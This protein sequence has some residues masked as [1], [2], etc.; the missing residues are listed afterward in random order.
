[1]EAGALEALTA[2]LVGLARGQPAPPRAALAQEPG[3][4]Q[5]KRSTS[6]V[7]VIPVTGIITYKRSVFSEFF[8]GTALVNVIAEINTAVDTPGVGAI[9]MPFDSPGGTASGLIET[10]AVIRAARRVKPVVAVVD[11]LAASAAFWLAT[12]ATEIVITPSGHTGSLG[13]FA[14]HLSF[15]EALKKA[16]VK[17]TFISST[18]EKV[19]Q[20]EALPLS[21]EAKAAA[22]REVDL[23]Y[24]AFLS[25][26]ALGRGKEV[27]QVR[28]NFGRGRLV[29]AKD[30]V[31]AGLVDR[32]GTLD[33]ALSATL[34]LL[35]RGS[36][37]A[38]APAGGTALH[39]SLPPSRPLS[40]Y[41]HFLAMQRNLRELKSTP[42][43]RRMLV[44]VAKALSTF[45]PPRPSSKPSSNESKVAVNPRWRRLAILEHG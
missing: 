40:D 35:Q 37:G 24:A 22:Q 36:R 45:T 4:R 18:P 12:Q 9:L 2:T 7:A 1:M 20:S 28:R 5:T 27:V 16:G 26:V 39:S 10:A 41:D 29:N 38:T 17:P 21:D 42:A 19:E 43:R 25:D 13:V 32:I 6:A 14:V 30:A 8:G 3:R 44:H 11:P 31:S 15:A 23:V 34:L 33:Q